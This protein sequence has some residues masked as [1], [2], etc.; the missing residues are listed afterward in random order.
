MNTNLRI[1]ENKTPPRNI[2]VV[3]DEAPGETGYYIVQKFD[4]DL[5][6][7]KHLERQF[8]PRWDLEAFA[9]F[10]PTDVEEHEPEE[11]ICIDNLPP[12]D[13]AMQIK[14]NSMDPE[15]HS[16]DMVAYKRTN[17]RRGGLLFGRMYVVA[18]VE[19]GE[20]HIVVKYVDESERHGYY[21]LRSANPDY[22]PWDIPRD[23]VRYLGQV[24]A[25]FRLYTAGNIA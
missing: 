22:E 20:E 23:S 15:L 8:I 17:S 19:D 3:H 21:T 7:E 16:G 4:C 12:C 25:S 10:M 11:F 9:G 24:R 2:I 1:M 5:F 6:T 18:Y 13:G 14:G